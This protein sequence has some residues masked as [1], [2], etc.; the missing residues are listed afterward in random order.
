[1]GLLDGGRHTGNETAAADRHQDV[2]NIRHLCQDLQPDRPLSRHYQIIVKRMD[3]ER[4]ACLAGSHRGGVGFIEI[5]AAEDNF[6]TII[7]GGK[8]LLRRRA[9]GHVHGCPDTEQICRKS[10]SLGM[11]PC[12][13][14]DDAVFQGL[15]RHGGHEVH[16]AANLEGAGALQVLALEP[17]RNAEPVAEM[18]GVDQFGLSDPL[19]QAVGS[20]VDQCIIEEGICHGYASAGAAASREKGPLPTSV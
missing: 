7:A 6:S 12:R 17:E 2:G 3:K 20:F 11:V 18:V 15:L 1:M 10:D 19:F 13:G 9:F 5:A 4:A 14:G 8:D 16:G